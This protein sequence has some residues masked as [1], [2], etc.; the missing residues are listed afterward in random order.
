MAKIGQQASDQDELRLN[1]SRVGC[2][3]NGAAAA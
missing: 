3:R 1:W 2:A